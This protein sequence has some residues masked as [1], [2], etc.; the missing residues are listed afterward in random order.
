M[1][2]TPPPLRLPAVDTI[3][4]VVDGLQSIIDWSIDTA[5]PVG[6]FALVYKRATIAVRDAIDAG[7][8]DDGQR[9]TRFGVAFARRYFDAV[10]SRFAGDD[11]TPT[12]VWQVAF[13][14]NASDEPIILQH[15]LTAMTA[16]D[17]FD[18]GIAAAMIAGDSLEPLAADFNAVNAI[19][20]SQ[21]AGVLDSIEQVSPGVTRYRK[22]LIGNEI[23]FGSA[24]LKRSRGL[25]WTFAQQLTFELES[26]CTNVIDGYN[27]LIARSISKYLKPTW[28]IS[29]IVKVIAR[30]ESRNVAYNVGVL[31]DVTSC[32]VCT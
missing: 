14:A 23:G 9:M 8:F 27:T 1:P 20:T 16:H 28:P 22:L 2:S 25:A 10:T 31:D 18:L 24:Y 5:S 17:T 29:R 4:E 7:M 21:I 26:N 6:Y 13:D 32:S 11:R 19:L 12:Q 15:I 3:G 30:E